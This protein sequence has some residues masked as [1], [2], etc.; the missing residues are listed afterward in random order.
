MLVLGPSGS[1][2]SSLVR[3]GLLPDLMAPGVVGGVT[4]WRHVAIQPMD[5]G[6]DPAAG[7]R[8]ARCLP[9]RDAAKLRQTEHLFE[10][11]L[12]L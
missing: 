10:K 11:V 5:L 3:A 7:G 8:A 1:G 6:A 2:K 12:V 4:T 9:Y